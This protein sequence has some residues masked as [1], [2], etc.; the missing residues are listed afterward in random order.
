MEGKFFFNIV[1]EGDQV[2]LASDDDNER[3]LWVQA[4]YRATGQSHKPVLATMQPNKLSNTQLSRLQGGLS[5]RSFCTLAVCS[6]DV[7]K[8]WLV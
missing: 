5:C 4:I 3:T 8:R 1:K 2:F 7:I 6:F